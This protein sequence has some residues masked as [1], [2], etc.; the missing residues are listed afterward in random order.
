LIVVEFS[1]EATKFVL[2]SI[3]N[4]NLQVGQPVSVPVRELNL[5]T[6]VHKTSKKLQEKK[7][8]AD[9]ES[10]L[11]KFQAGIKKK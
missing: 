1:T 5:K 2:V 11:Y 6:Y 4:F 7:E 10:T 3:I 8:S 9:F